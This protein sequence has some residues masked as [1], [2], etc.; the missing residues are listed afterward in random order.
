MSDTPLLFTYDTLLLDND[1]PFMKE[2]PF[3]VWRREWM[4]RH[5][6]SYQPCKKPRN[7]DNKKRLYDNVRQIIKTN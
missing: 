5:K 3:I 1:L 4:I 6:P 7:V 2:D